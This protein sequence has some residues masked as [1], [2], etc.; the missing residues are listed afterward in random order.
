VNVKIVKGATVKF[1]GKIAIGNFSTTY[2]KTGPVT[3]SFDMANVGA[4]T[5]DNLGA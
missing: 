2:N 5:T 3:Y 1:A 4:P